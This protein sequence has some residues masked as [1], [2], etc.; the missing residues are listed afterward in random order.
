MA[1]FILDIIL[2]LPKL[3]NWILVALID[4]LLGMWPSSQALG[5]PTVAE[6]LTSV[7]TS[8]P[9]FPWSIVAHLFGVVVLLLG[10]ILVVK[11]VKIFWP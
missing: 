11:A 4:L 1:K 5:I 7:S 9:F 3:I 10:A 2:L 6:M 8:F